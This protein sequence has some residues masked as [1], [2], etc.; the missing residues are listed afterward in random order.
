MAPDCPLFLLFF[1]DCEG[2]IQLW[3]YMAGDR[4]TVVDDEP[5]RMKGDSDCRF[6]GKEARFPF[7]TSPE[8]SSS[9]TRLLDESRQVLVQIGRNSLV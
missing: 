6:L 7:Y 1:K 2:R 4:M 3:Q 9:L 8:D 5:F